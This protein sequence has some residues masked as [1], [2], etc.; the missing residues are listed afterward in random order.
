MKYKIEIKMF[1]KYFLIYLKNKSGNII[2]AEMNENVFPEFI[3]NYIIN[4]LRNQ[5]HE[6]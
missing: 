2:F 4:K 5:T 6:N 3:D 1:D